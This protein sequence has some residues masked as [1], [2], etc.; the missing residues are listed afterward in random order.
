MRTKPRERDGNQQR[1]FRGSNSRKTPAAR[2]SSSGGTKESP[3]SRGE[4]N[5]AVP[6]SLPLIGVPL[7]VPGWWYQI[8]PFCT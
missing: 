1:H 2:P 8:T 6:I 3:A 4:T 5:R 7:R